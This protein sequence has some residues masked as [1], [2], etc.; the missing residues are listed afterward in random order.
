MPFIFRWISE[1]S[2]TLKKLITKLKYYSLNLIDLKRI[3]YNIK[4]YN[5]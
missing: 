3:I 2:Y 1:K 5:I 4:N